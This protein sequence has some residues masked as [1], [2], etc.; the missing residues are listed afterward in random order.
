M[1]KMKNVLARIAFTFAA[2][3]AMSADLQ[4]G[5][6]IS[7]KIFLQLHSIEK[8]AGQLTPF[9][10]APGRDFRVIDGDSLAM[11]DLNIR[12]ADI[13]APL[14]TQRCNTPDGSY[15]D[16]AAVARQRVRTIVDQADQVQ[17]FSTEQ[18]VYGRHL[19]TCDA[20]GVD[21]GALLV[22]EGL[23]WP[24]HNQGRYLPEASAAQANARGIWQAETPT[25]WDLQDERD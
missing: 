1:M 9:V 15:W 22:E 11:G 25:P 12:L 23:A 20:D 13:D 10:A 19:A 16:C 24:H 14:T 2:S 3:A 18:D 4:P 6:P 5:D 21:L 8:L 7:A 17:C